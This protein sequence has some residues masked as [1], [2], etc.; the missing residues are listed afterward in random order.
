VSEPIRRLLGFS[1]FAHTLHVLGL[2]RT[3]IPRRRTSVLLCRRRLTAFLGVGATAFEASLCDIMLGVHWCCRGAAAAAGDAHSR[4]AARHDAPE[5]LGN[6]PPPCL[7]F[8]AFVFWMWLL[9]T[10]STDILFRFAF[11]LHDFSRR[12]GYLSTY[13]RVCCGVPCCSASVLCCVV[14]CC[15]V[16]CYV[17]LCCVVLCCVVLCCVVLSCVVLC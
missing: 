5:T 4:G 12:R 1:G 14:L 8:S 17:V 7:S 3:A 13:V 11:R 10:S 2:Y 9:T 16:L 15:V 6:P